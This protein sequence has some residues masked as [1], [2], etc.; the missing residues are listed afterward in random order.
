ML[1]TCA[2]Q[3]LS[4]AA[5]RQPREL[6]EVGLLPDHIPYKNN[7]EASFRVQQP[8]S[9]PFN[10]ILVARVAP[11]ARTSTMIKLAQVSAST[12]NSSAHCSIAPSSRLSKQH[13]GAPGE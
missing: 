9:L 5:A 1:L 11:D 6:G 10:V 13:H 12:A 3:G 4:A 8:G 7:F 2:Q